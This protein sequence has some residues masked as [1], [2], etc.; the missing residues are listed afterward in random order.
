MPINSNNYIV[1]DFET[2]D[3]DTDS[4]PI[5]ELAA[6]AID[7]RTLEI[8]KGS[9]FHSFIKPTAEELLLVKQEALDVNK[10]TAKDWENAPLLVDVWKSF[11]KYV[12]Q[13][14]KPGKFLT[15]P[16]AAGHNIRNFDMKIID[17]LCKKYGQWDSKWDNQTL[18]YNMIKMDTM[19][20]MF[21]FFEGCK[22]GPEKY[23]MDSLR[24]FFGI[25]SE[26]SHRADKDVKDTAQII[27][28]FLKF[29]RQ[30]TNKNVG[31]F[32]GAFA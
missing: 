7:G 13:Y 29:Q 28:R 21:M 5:L 12:E 24:E 10:I 20:L 11:T 32:K 25:P 15:Q 17:R 30:V 16:I 14:N 23:K 2:G 1:F 31:K 6:V 19:D 26:G 4:C 9:E 27:C 18:F 3:I 22:E 8:I